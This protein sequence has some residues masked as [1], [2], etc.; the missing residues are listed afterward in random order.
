MNILEKEYIEARDLE[1]KFRSAPRAG[2]VV[3]GRRD[4]S[5]QAIMVP[6]EEAV[7]VCAELSRSIYCDLFR[8]YENVA[9]RSY[10]SQLA[11][12]EPDAEMCSKCRNFFLPVGKN[13]KC[14]YCEAESTARAAVDEILTQARRGCGEN[15]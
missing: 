15:G 2:W 13:G 6:R 9:L 3:K 1:D 11:E 4:R 14:P 10:M 8:L 5:N 12:D 7:K